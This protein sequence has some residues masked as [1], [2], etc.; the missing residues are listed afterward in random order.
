M[1]ESASIIA[2]FNNQPVGYC[3]LIEVKCWG[4]DNVPWIFDICIDPAFHGQGIGKAMSKRVMNI[5]IEKQY[6]IVGLA[7]TKTNIYAK[8]LYENLGFE[9]LDRFYEF[10]NIK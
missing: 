6:P 9:Y 2:Y 3:T 7:V 4:Y 10:I 5:L 1:V 8:K